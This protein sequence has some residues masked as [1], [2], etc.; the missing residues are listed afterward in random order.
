[1]PGTISGTIPLES[2]HA[3]EWIKGRERRE[4]TCWQETKT[5]T[6]EQNGSKT[7]MGRK[8]IQHFYLFTGSHWFPALFEAQGKLE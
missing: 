1:M 4:K 8:I 2:E 5:D 6:W 3:P 7:G